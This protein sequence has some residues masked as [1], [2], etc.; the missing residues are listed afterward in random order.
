MRGSAMAEQ[1]KSIPGLGAAA[2][3]VDSGERTSCGATNPHPEEPGVVHLYAPRQWA[4]LSS[5][6]KADPT[7][8]E[9]PYQ[10]TGSEMERLAHLFG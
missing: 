4:D 8:I 5:R 2:V 9:L 3:V 1:L 7:R 6:A 10:I